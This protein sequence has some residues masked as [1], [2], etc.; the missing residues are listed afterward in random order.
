MLARAFIEFSVLIVS[1]TTA[2]TP[3]FGAGNYLPFQQLFPSKGPIQSRL[4]VTRNTR[5]ARG[6]CSSH[7]PPSVHH[8]LDGS[9]TYNQCAKIVEGWPALICVTTTLPRAYRFRIRCD[10]SC[11]ARILILHAAASVQSLCSSTLLF[12]MSCDVCLEFAGSHPVIGNAEFPRRRFT[13]FC[14]LLC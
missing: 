3:H 6:P 2:R 9:R 12:R 11:C 7:F 13:A 1:K 14:P 8:I 5:I 10:V 4:F